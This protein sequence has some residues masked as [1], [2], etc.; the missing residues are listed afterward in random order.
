MSHGPRGVLNV[1]S[2]CIKDGQCSKQYIKLFT[3]EMTEMTTSDDGYTNYLW[4]RTEDGG[5]LCEIRWTNGILT[6][7]NRWVVPY[8]QA[9]GAHINTE[10][11]RSVKSINVNTS[12]DLAT[13]NI[14]NLYDEV[15][16]FQYGGYISSSETTWRIF[17]L[18]IH[19]RFP[20][21]VHL[22][23]HLEN[24]QRVY[25]HAYN[26]YERVQNPRIQLSLF[27]YLCCEDDFAKI[28]LYEVVPS[29]YTYN[30]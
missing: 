28:L 25:F 8:S 4:P 27:S 26:L 23:V 24:G 11:Y 17:S 16:Q 19:E 18:P 14:Q 6:I 29:Y 15:L 13:I 2:P 12:S 21:V 22:G 3:S 20:P 1:Q 5:F 9:Y 10:L 7:D 30:K